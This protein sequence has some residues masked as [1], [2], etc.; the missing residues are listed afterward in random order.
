VKIHKLNPI[1]DPRWRRFIESHPQSSV[2]HTPEWLQALQRTYNYEASAVTTSAPGEEL[3]NGLVFCAVESWVTGRRLVSLPFSDHCEPLVR[4]EE[5]LREIVGELKPEVDAG[6]W[7]HVEIRQA[8]MVE[9]APENLTGA[10]FCL[11]KLD[12]HPD[13]DKLMAGFHKTAVQ[14]MIRR[15]DREPLVCEEGRSESLLAKFYSL[16]VLTRQRQSLPPQPLA[17]F[18]NLAE[19]LKDMLTVRVALK[20]DVPV[21]GILT[22][23]YKSTL[24]Y[25]YSC[26]NR[27]FRNCGGTPF[28][29]WKAIQSAKEEGKVELDMGRSDWD[30]PGLIEFKDRW[31]ATRSTLNYFRYPK[32]PDKPTAWQSRAAKGILEHLP[33]AVL[34][35]A[36]KLLYRHIG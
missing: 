15:A 2:F 4:S 32:R 28:L 11:H 26:S 10:S 25:K 29:L 17:W 1:H 3:V 13:L 18:R 22:V 33:S 6:R 21:A 16:L 31:S 7:K 27:E 5:E 19:S 8:A 34:S 14:Q 24:V 9:S 30:N 35:R 36:G 23:R 12:L 20:G